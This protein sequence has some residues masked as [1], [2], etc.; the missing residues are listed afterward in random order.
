MVVNVRRRRLRIALGVLGAFV[1]SLAAVVLLGLVLQPAFVHNG[2]TS[3]DTHVT[4]WFV[5]HR[6]DASTSLMRAV[7]WLGSS[8]VIIPLTVIVATIL[9]VRHSLALAVYLAVAVAGA[10]LLSTLAKRIIG[11][12]RPPAVVRLAHVTSSSFPSGHATQAAA[13]YLALA[14]IA[15]CFVHRTTA[16]ALIWAAAVLVPALVGVSR[17]YLGV[18][19]ATDVLG[20]WLLGAIWISGLTAAFRPFIPWDRTRV[21]IDEA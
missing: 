1:V 21:A 16:R 5:D 9:V 10:S 8:W 7:T 18:H 3:F 11:R 20:G 12:D 13:T 14:V 2:P 15:C 6:A 19:W 4:R 17:V